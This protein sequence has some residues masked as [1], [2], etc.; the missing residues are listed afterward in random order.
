MA[1]NADEQ[2]RVAGI[3]R[4]QCRRPEDA[5]PDDDADAQGDG[6]AHAQRGA[7]TVGIGH[8]DGLLERGASHGGQNHGCQ[9]WLLGVG[10]QADSRRV[11]DQPA[12]SIR[13]APKIAATASTVVAS[14]P[15][16]KPGPRLAGSA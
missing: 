13:T 1:Q 11:G 14:R 6:M 9:N 15:I 4:D 5:G 16:M 8:D 12:S 2:G 10:A 7:R 3:G